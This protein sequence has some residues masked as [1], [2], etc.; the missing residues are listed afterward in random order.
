[1][2]L[3]LPD[4]VIKFRWYGVPLRYIVSPNHFLD[5]YRLRINQFD[6]YL[7]PAGSLLY[8]DYNYQPFTPPVPGMSP[9]AGTGPGGGALLSSAKPVDIESPSAPTSRPGAAGVAAPPT[10]GNSLAFGWNLQ[11]HYLDMKFHSPTTDGTAG[12][13]PLFLSFPFEFLFWD[14]DVALDAGNT[15]FGPQ[16]GD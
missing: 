14:P 10:N 6:F 1:P 11:P 3:P 7:W 15:I 12:G 5:K 8:V 9:Y 13:A 4:G 2:R 16:P